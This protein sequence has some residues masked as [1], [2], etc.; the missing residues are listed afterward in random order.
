MG[1]LYKAT[2][3]KHRA[4][5]CIC[6]PQPLLEQPKGQ[7]LET[8]APHQTSNTES[9]S[10]EHPGV[11]ITH[12]SPI[13]LLSPPTRTSKVEAPRALLLGGAKWTTYPS[14]T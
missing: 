8:T 9:G 12:S 10:Q 13:P 11:T 2:V 3:P 5:L 1:V 14:P 4:A 6:P 7:S